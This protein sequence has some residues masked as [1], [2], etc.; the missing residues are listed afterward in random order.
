MISLNQMIKAMIDVINPVWPERRLTANVFSHRPF[1][2]KISG[3]FHRSSE[4]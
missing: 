4:R 1:R 2:D 3:S